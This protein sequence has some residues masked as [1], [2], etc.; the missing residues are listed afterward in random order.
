MT[1]HFGCLLSPC[2]YLIQ[3]NLCHLQ[4]TH[5]TNQGNLFG[6]YPILHHIRFVLHCSLSGVGFHSKFVRSSLQIDQNQGFQTQIDRIRR[7]K[8]TNFVVQV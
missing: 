2:V 8:L 1:T 4:I 5:Q 7:N 6:S 3:S